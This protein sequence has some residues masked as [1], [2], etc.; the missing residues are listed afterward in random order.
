[1]ATSYAADTP[2]NQAI[3]DQMVNGL[4]SY[5]IALRKLNQQHAALLQ[6]WFNGNPGGS[7]PATIVG[8]YMPASTVPNSG[9]GLAGATQVL[10][11]GVSTL[12]GYLQTTDGLNDAAHIDVM[13]P[14]AGPGNL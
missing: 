7:S 1:M 10:A 14:F 4:R 11:S 13:V 5:A 6:F 8:G 3:V 2:A 9:S 12:A